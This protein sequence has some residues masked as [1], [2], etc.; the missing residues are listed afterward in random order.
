MGVGLEDLISLDNDAIA[1]LVVFYDINAIS[2]R[3]KG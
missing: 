1:A 3:S 2:F